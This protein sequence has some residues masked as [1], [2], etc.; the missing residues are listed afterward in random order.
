[1]IDFAIK[2]GANAIKFQTWNTELLQ[3]KNAKK[4][5]YQKNIKNKTYYEIIKNL[6]PPQ[7]DQKKIYE[8]CKKTGIIFLSTPYDEQSVDF[9]DDLGVPAFKIS[10]SDLANHILLKH[11]ATIPTLSTKKLYLLMDQILLEKIIRSSQ[12]IY[13]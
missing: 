9:L 10:S 6:E 12:N 1:M 4:P 7:N 2:Y 11:V 3:L 8:R 13:L 5:F